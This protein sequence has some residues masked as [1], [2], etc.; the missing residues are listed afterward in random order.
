MPARLWR[1]LN[2]SKLTVF[3]L[4]RFSAEQKDESVM[5]LEQLDSILSRLCC[6]GYK[7]QSLS[8][9]LDE[10]QTNSKDHHVVFTID[11][12]YHCFAEAAEVFK[13]YDCQATV[14]LTTE[15]ISGRSWMWWDKL[16]YVLEYTKLQQLTINTEGFTFSHD[17][18]NKQQRVL[19]LNSITESLK[20]MPQELRLRTIGTIVKATN[21]D[22]PQTVPTQYRA[23]TW[24]Q[25]RALSTQGFE[26]AAHTLT[27]PILRNLND[28]DL[29]LEVS[30]SIDK[31]NKELGQSCRLFAYPNGDKN[32]FGERE[33]QA[34][35][36]CGIELAVT[37][38]PGHID[39]KMLTPGNKQR[40]T[41]P[42]FYCPTDLHRTMVIAS[43]LRGLLKRV[44]RLPRNA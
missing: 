42:R 34:L 18:E 3:T 44:T 11:D 13:K 10:L 12:G 24:N 39:R 31:L 4:H 36:A 37:T 14:F 25:V 19:A 7:I 6:D 32:D 41:L 1:R 23:L 15:F 16:E 38:I 30:G 33:Q 8:N 29:Q 17:L 43:G 27:H 5:S 9:A 20:K 22:L 26:F 2:G 21:V 35:A 40:L 28:T